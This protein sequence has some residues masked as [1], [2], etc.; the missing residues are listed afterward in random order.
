MKHKIDYI[1][2]SS[3]HGIVYNFIHP[4]DKLWSREPFKIYHKK[5]IRRRPRTKGCR[6]R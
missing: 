1:E 2:L 5:Q 3:S 4:E 6:V